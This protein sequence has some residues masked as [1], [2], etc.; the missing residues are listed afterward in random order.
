MITGERPRREEDEERGRKEEGK[1][2]GTRQRGPWLEEREREIERE[3]EE[4]VGGEA[5]LY[6][7]LT[8]T[9]GNMGPIPICKT[10]IKSERKIS[11]G[12]Q[13]SKVNFFSEE[14][15]RTTSYVLIPAESRST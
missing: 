12:N 6:Q 7:N 10:G 13:V 3:R 2:S 1:A 9:W 11:V 14:V 15:P 5:V 4:Q 8:V